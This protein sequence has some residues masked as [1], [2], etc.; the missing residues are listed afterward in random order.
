MNLKWP[1]FKV[2]R[3]TSKYFFLPNEY[4]KA[5]TSQLNEALNISPQRLWNKPT[6]FQSTLV[7]FSGLGTLQINKKTFRGN[8]DSQFDPF[9]FDVADTLL[10][11]TSTLISGFL[12]FNRSSPHFGIDLSFQN[13]RSKSLL[14]MELKHALRKVSE[15]VSDGTS[16]RNF[17]QS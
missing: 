12:Y 5:Y 17:Q 2:M 15:P 14:T 16:P 9:R 4:V 13:N 3:T 8:F 7:R 6:G 10:L 11:S 1:H